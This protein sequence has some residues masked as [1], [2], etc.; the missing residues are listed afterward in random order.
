MSTAKWVNNYPRRYLVSVDHA[1][2]E[3]IEELSSDGLVFRDMDHMLRALVS[4]DLGERVTQTLASHACAVM[5]DASTKHFEAT[6]SP[7]VR[8]T[9]RNIQ[10]LSAA[11]LHELATG[12]Y[13]ELRSMAHRASDAAQ[14]RPV[15]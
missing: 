3:T 2:H 14:A 10:H 15:A 1:G 6:H 5:R 7:S 9:L 11:E 13:R 12:A 8:H 4:G